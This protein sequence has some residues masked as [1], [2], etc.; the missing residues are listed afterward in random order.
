MENKKFCP[1]CGEPGTQLPAGD[2]GDA[3]TWVKFDNEECRGYK[4]SNP[5]CAWLFGNPVGNGYADPKRGLRSL[6]EVL[7]SPSV[8]VSRWPPAAADSTS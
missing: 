2:Y 5:S 8:A 6:D 1:K 4:C 7:E 3:S